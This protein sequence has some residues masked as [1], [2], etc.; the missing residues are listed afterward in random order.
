MTLTATETA[1][2]SVRWKGCLLTFE[3]TNASKRIRIIG[4]LDSDIGNASSTVKYKVASLASFNANYQNVYPVDKQYL[5][6]TING[7]PY[8][9]RFYMTVNATEGY[10]AQSVYLIT[11][12]KVVIPSGTVIMIDEAYI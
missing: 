6:G 9:F 2:S 7:T 1:T 4:A 8:G 11:T 12:E 3:R 10:D 5:V